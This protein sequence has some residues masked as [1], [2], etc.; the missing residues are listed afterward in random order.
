MFEQ[1]ECVFYTCTKLLKN[2]FLKEG[3]A[4]N[5]FNN[6]SQQTIGKIKTTNCHPSRLL[7]SPR[8][9]HVDACIAKLI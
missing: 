6:L 5:N 8:L 2:N 7:I 3:N 4:S 9:F 1:Q